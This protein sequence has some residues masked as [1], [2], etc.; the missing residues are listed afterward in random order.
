MWVSDGEE[1]KCATPILTFP[2]ILR[3]MLSEQAARHGTCGS[4]SSYLKETETEKENNI[5]SKLP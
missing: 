1:A 4:L 5:K 2:L 3:P